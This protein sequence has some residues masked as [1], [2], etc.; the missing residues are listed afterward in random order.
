MT[1]KLSRRSESPCS[2]CCGRRPRQ[3]PHQV[4]P[5]G[6]LLIETRSKTKQ[7]SKDGCPDVPGDAGAWLWLVWQVKGDRVVLAARFPYNS[8]QFHVHHQCSYLSDLA[9]AMTIILLGISPILVLIWPPHLGLS[10]IWIPHSIHCL[11]NLIIMFPYF[12]H[13]IAINWGLCNPLIF[14]Q[15]QIVPRLVRLHEKESLSVSDFRSCRALPTTM[16]FFCLN[17]GIL[18]DVYGKKP[19][20]EWP[21]TDG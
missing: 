20:D 11:I 3:R 5:L 15:R 13:E 12:P 8:H 4:L 17:N 18:W 2:R 19:L 6:P 16:F 9:I 10:E 14:R 7:L 1:S 21:H